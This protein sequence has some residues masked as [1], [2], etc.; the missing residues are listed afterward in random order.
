M[1]IVTGTADTLPAGLLFD[2][3]HYRY[4]VFVERLGWQL[5]HH[6]RLELDQF[7]RR[8]TLYVIARQRGGE[9]RGVARLLPTDQPYLLATAFAQLLP[10]RPL[11][12]S[13]EIW[14]LSRFAAV[15][16]DASGREGTRFGASEVALALL[17]GAMQ[18]AAQRGARAL[19]TASPI[20]IERL[21]RIAGIAAS[22]MAPPVAI[23][24]HRMFACRIELSSTRPA[25]AS[26]SGGDGGTLAPL[27]RAVPVRPRS[28]RRRSCSP[29]SV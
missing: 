23:G 24:G 18:L 9:L 19:V 29:I 22:R 10:G 4:R 14:E 1:N 15:D 7:D 16:L 27:S 8:D 6:G 25:P 28:P 17:R 21:L 11:P 26:A 13:P 20:G 12:R 3:A 2:M 5:Q